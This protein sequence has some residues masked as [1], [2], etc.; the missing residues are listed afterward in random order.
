MKNTIAVVILFTILFAAATC[1]PAE[2]KKDNT[3]TGAPQTTTIPADAVPNPGGKTYSYTDKEGKKWTYLRTPFG[4]SRVAA[5]DK[6]APVPRDPS[7]IKVIDKGDTVRF[8]RPSPLGPMSYEKKKSELTE[9]ERRI[10][11]SSQAD[12]S[13]AD[14][15]KTDSS[16]TG[17]SKGKTQ[18]NEKTQ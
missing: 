5:T 9:E 6:P 11:D 10:V 3:A 14:S 2:D 17:A 15:N 1:A 13:R 7:R 4:I 18:Q 16:R 8:E 12:S